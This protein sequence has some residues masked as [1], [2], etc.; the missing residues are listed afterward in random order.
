MNNT[1]NI[2]KLVRNLRQQSETRIIYEGYT[3]TFEEIFKKH[4]LKNV[5]NKKYI[6]NLQM[7][8]E[9]KISVMPIRTSYTINLM[10]KVATNSLDDLRVMYDIACKTV[11]NFKSFDLT[12]ELAHN[13]YKS[14]LTSYFLAHECQDTPKENSKI[15]YWSELSSNTKNNCMK[16]C[17][18]HFGVPG[19]EQM[20]KKSLIE[21]QEL[22]QNLALW[23]FESDSQKSLKNLHSVYLWSKPCIDY[24]ILSIQIQL[25]QIN[26]DPLQSVLDL[27]SVMLEPQP[28][29]KQFQIE[30]G[31]LSRS[32]EEIT[33]VVLMQQGLHKQFKNFI[34]HGQT[35]EFSF[36]TS[37]PFVKE[38]MKMY[39][40]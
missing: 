31:G 19:W 10:D 34:V 8:V 36:A 6:E 27:K 29:K 9:D 1:H 32:L 20:I 5:K 38:S 14:K 25:S 30:F 17:I 23:M 39:F 18:E 33:Q 3:S 16:F 2:L 11:F 7:S 21:P 28:Y 22:K 4:P 35:P 26:I 40:D 12:R 24:K 13:W 15:N 37:N